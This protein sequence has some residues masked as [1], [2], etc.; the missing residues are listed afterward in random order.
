MTSQDELGDF[1]TWLGDYRT[2]LAGASRSDAA[3]QAE[4]DQL[5]EELLVAEEELRAQHDELAAVRLELEGLAA[6]N[7]ELF[8]ASPVAHVITDPRGMIVDASRATWELLG[9]AGG[10]KP[11]RPIVTLFA[12]GCRRQVRS[13]ISLAVVGGDPH[14]ADLTLAGGDAEFAVHVI[15]QTRT[16]PQTGTAL[17]RWQLTPLASAQTTPP[18]RLVASQPAAATRVEA[19]PDGELTRLLSLARA[20]LA[21]ELHPDAGTEVLLERVVELT[22]RWVPGGERA[23]VCR[24]E[25]DADLET[26]AASD[27][28]A[29]ACDLLQVDLGEGPMIDSITEHRTVR[30]DDLRD[31]QRWPRFAPA[32]LELG[33]RSVLACELPLTPRSNATL[34]LYSQQPDAFGLMAELLIPVF[35]SRASI[36]LAHADEVY[37]LRRAMKSRQVIGQAVGILMERHKLSADQAFDRLVSASQRSHIKLREVATRV[38][39]T[40]QEPDQVA[41]H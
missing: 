27:D 18:L 40:G 26:S 1:L 13:L 20:D 17:L 19:D 28:V 4:I 37:N 3:E 34:N 22:K 11:R 14:E 8:G 10:A 7:E 16:E 41:D 24:Q 39:E 31:E 30:V 12:T 21:S 33:V 32:A 38:T 15:V 35:A 5:V 29:S 9:A 23:S 6:R 36:A 2:R 25:R